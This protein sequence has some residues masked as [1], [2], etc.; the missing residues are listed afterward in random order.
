MIYKA[1]IGNEDMYVEIIGSNIVKVLKLADEQIKENPNL[2]ILE[3][4]D[5]KNQL[6]DLDKYRRRIHRAK[7]ADIEGY[8]NKTDLSKCYRSVQQM[9]WYKYDEEEYAKI[10]IDLKKI[11]DSSKSLDEFKCNIANYIR[12]LENQGI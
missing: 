3:I 5:S 2:K 6:I 10:K 7:R 12:T 1:K 4:R 8:M 9:M 11:K